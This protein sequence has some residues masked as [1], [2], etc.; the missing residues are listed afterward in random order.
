MARSH[1]RVKE[2]LIDEATEMGMGIRDLKVLTTDPYMVGTDADYRDSKW[3]ADHWDKMMASRKNP[4]HIR[5]FYYWLY[6]N[7][8]KPDGKMFGAAKDPMKD[9]RWLMKA[10]QT[11]RYLGIGTWQGLIDIKHPD[12]AD[13]DAYDDDTSLYIPPTSVNE[14]VQSDLRDMIDDIM[15][16]ALNLSPRYNLRGYQTY[17]CEVWVEK[18]SMGRIIEPICRSTGS[19]YQ[20]LVGQASVEKVDMLVRRV[21]RAVEADKKVRI[22]YIADWDRYGWSMVSAV[23]RKLEFGV[24]MNGL[25]SK[26]DVKLTRLALNED[27]IRKYKLPKAPKHGEDVVELDALEARHPGELGKIVKQAIYP[28]VDTDRPKEVREEN[29]AMKERLSAILEERLRP[30]LDEAL[31]GIKLDDVDI[32]LKECIDE[33]YEP[34]ERE[35]EVEDDGNG[36]VYDSNRGWFEQLARFKE[37]KSERDEEG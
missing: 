34:P 9:W 35:H 21:Q 27:Q 8:R 10:S 11:A 20:P 13:F 14:S 23:A 29:A 22:F 1:Q 3:A 26:A 24:I 33:D 28:Y 30:V 19:V 5:G 17:H 16:R 4:M 12:P 18:N 25:G 31:N 36:W 32:D 2:I 7:A 6:N 15:N 37:Y